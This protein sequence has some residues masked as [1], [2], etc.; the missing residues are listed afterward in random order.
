MFPMAQRVVDRERDTETAA[1]STPES[2]RLD[3]PA[4][5]PPIAR[6][7]KVEMLEGCRYRLVGLFAA[8][9]ALFHFD[10]SE[11]DLEVRRQPCPKRSQL[12]RHGRRTRT[13]GYRRHRAYL[14]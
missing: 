5:V 14:F 2:K 6:H 8:D 3:V 7:I 4:P 11:A 13:F 12:A 10:C 1:E 9:D